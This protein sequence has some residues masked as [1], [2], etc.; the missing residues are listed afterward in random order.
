MASESG[1][2]VHALSELLQEEPERFSFFRAL[3]LIERIT[4]DA[5][6]LGH[7]GPVRREAARLRPTGTLAFPNADVDAV[8]PR[9]K[10]EGG[11]FDVTSSILGLYGANSP[12]P[13]FYTA[14]IIQ[15]DASEATDVG[16]LLLDILNHRVMSLLY[17]AWLKYRWEYEYE[18]GAADA[19]SKLFLGLTGLSHLDGIT[20]GAEGLIPRARLL[21]Y[22]GTLTQH[23]RNAS[24][25]GAVIS[26]YFRIDSV[27]VEQCVARRVPIPEADQTKLGRRNARLGSEVVIG[28]SVLDRGGKVRLRLGPLGAD[29]YRRLCPGGEDYA[30]LCELARIV[31]PD[32]MLFDVEMILEPEAVAPM[33]LTSRSAPDRAARLGWDS[34]LIS[35][36]PEEN[37]EVT[38]G[39]A[40]TTWASSAPPSA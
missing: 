12:L 35:S 25:A 16:Q 32:V 23:P 11:G 4:P 33:Q 20:D 22:A 9:P 27:A 8:I 17:R 15:R 40:S 24:A 19:T 3:W 28:S 29:E 37:S 30:P 10:T 31:L 21:R 39:A 14:D 18:A 38:F 2:A 7:D 26:D 6:K 34:W 13:G 1:T 36:P 5:V